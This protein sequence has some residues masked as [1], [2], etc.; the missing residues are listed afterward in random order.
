MFYVSAGLCLQVKLQ[1]CL[2]FKHKVSTKGRAPKSQKHF[3]LFWYPDCFICPEFGGEICLN[4]NT[5]EV[6]AVWFVL[7]GNCVSV[8]GDVNWFHQVFYL[9]SRENFQLTF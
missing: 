2:P 4:L 9:F 3:Y 1:R 5:L 7:T 6:N 8:T